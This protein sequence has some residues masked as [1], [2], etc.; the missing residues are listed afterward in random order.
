MDVSDVSE[1][2]SESDV[3]KHDKELR[4]ELGQK[5]VNWKAVAQLQALT[6]SKRWDIISKITGL[7]AVEKVLDQ[8]PF[9]EHE[10][11]VSS[12]ILS[13]LYYAQQ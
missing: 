8:F 13:S 9:F 7:K 11:V 2:Q 3:Q 6:F 12:S 10:R 5:A 4:K 1:H